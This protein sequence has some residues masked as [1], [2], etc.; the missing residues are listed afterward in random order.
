M[1]HYIFSVVFLLAAVVVS[2][3][4]LATSSMYEL[5]GTLHNPSVAGVEKH[6]MIGATYRTMWEGIDGG[7]RTATVFGSAY[8]PSVKLGIGGYLYS[9]VTGPTKQ[10]GL[11]MAYAYHIPLKNDADFSLG[12]E[13]RFQQFSFDKAKLQASLG[14]DPVL[15]STNS[16]FTGD[17]GFG[18]AY[19]SKKFQAGASVSQLVQSKMDFYKLSLT[20]A[21]G[22]LPNRTEEARLYRHYYL[23]TS[24]KWD[25][26]GSTT[27]IPNA[28]LTYLPNAPLEFQAGARV[29]HS[30]IF[31]WGLAFRARQSWMI[32]AGV[33]IAKVFTVGYSFDIYRTPLSIY[34]NGSNAHEILLRYDFLKK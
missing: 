4:Q 21:T 8:I 25:A 33:H 17:A 12:I 11:Q 18:I 15:G 24:Y 1:K 9:D 32:S 26:D 31:W 13:G 16:K 22:A 20:G 14:N 7:P 19:T 6:G 29:E 34:D 5:Q 10:I 23:H 28:I 3:Q 30:E 2:A 27:I